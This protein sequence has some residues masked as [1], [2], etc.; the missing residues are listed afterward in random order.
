MGLLDMLQNAL[1]AGTP[2]QHFDQV[3]KTAPKDELGHGVAAALRS[4]QTP[5]FPNLVGQ[6]FGGS[7]APQQAGLLNQILASLGPGALSSVAGGALGRIL[8]PGSTQVTPEQA[9]QLSPSEVSEIAAKAESAQPGVV[10][11]VGQFYAEHAGL[12]KL[13]GGAA[14]ALT[15]AKMKERATSGAT[16]LR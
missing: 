10:D 15:L 12:L 4:D 7:S 5:P 8:Q 9:A 16:G 13:L 14:L 11:Q 1:D 2:E 3:A 6:L